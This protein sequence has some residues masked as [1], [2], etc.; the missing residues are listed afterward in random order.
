[1]LDMQGKMIRLGLT[2]VLIRNNT[3][4]LKFLR[5]MVSKSLN[6]HHQISTK[7]LV[8]DGFEIHIYNQVLKYEEQTGG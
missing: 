1:M 6:T 2:S 7:L 4:T 5:S 8:G 3:L